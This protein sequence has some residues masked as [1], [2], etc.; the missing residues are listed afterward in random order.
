MREFLFCFTAVAFF[1]FVP[2]SNYI[3]E[4]ICYTYIVIHQNKTY[5]TE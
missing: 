2:I 1:S 3:K 5:L 4:N